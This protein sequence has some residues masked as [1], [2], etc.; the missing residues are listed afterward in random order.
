LSGDVNIYNMAG[1]TFKPY[2]EFNSEL[3]TTFYDS[4][5]SY[6]SAVRNAA[7]HAAAAGWVLSEE[8]DSLVLDAEE[9]A[10]QFP[11]CVPDSTN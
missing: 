4:H 5:E 1:G 7:E 8:V 3:C 6:V 11:G 2:T 9:K 10:A